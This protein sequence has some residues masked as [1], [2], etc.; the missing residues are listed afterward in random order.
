MI[1]Q[2]SERLIYMLKQDVLWE[3]E[4]NPFITMLKSPKNLILRIHDNPQSHDGIRYQTG[5]AS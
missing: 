2:I 4:R 3:D 1:L 5:G